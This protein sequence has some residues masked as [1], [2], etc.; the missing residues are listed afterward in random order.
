M[1]FLNPNHTQIRSFVIGLFA[2]VGIAG[3]LA[4]PFAGHL[5]DKHGP[6]LGVS[7]GI[8]ATTIGWCILLGLGNQYVPAIVIGGFLSDF[9]GQV[10]ENELEQGLTA[11][12]AN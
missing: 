9:G 12:A 1:L 4:A 10:R 3:T 8:F 6:Y 7:C 2:V 5:I 11:V